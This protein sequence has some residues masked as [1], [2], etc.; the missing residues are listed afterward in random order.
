[1]ATKLTD[2]L[3]EALPAPARGNR[4]TYDTEA[5]GLGVRVT[6]AG[7]RAFV[8]NYRTKGGTERRITLGDP[9]D[10]TIIAARKVAKDLRRRVDGGEDPMGELHAVREAPTVADLAARFEA[11]HLTKR[12]TSTAGDYESMLRRDIL[13]EFGSRKVVEIETGDIEALHAKI[14]KGTPKRKAAPYAANR[15]VAVLSK[16][17]ALSIK[18]KMR[19]DNPVIGI[20]RAPEQKRQ[21]Y[22]SPA[23]IIRLSEALAAHPERASADAVR[24]LLLT[25]ARRGEVLS[26]S[27]NQFD[28]SAGA[29]TKPGA[30]TKQKTDHR[31]P[32]SAPALQLLGE[33]KTA[34]DVETE[35]RRQRGLAPIP[36]LFPGKDGKPL[37]EIKHFWAS[38]CRSAKIEGVRI[39]DLRHTHASILASLGL[40]LP[41]IGA[42]LGHTQAATTHRYAH[43]MDDPLRAATERLGAIV[44]GTGQTEGDVVPMAAGRRL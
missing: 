2:K 26:A 44:T 30:T 39:H 11:E 22:L 13:P 29:W 23:E 28:W 40:S 43:L 36:F 41:I 8:F 21:R 33:M 15:V 16:M 25:G 37:A 4:I 6:A 17:F 42:L 5:R 38:V 1:M 14:A 9:A 27:W 32:L 35:R 24:L 20:E 10:H 19:S 34:A 18:W 31:I 7:A 3:I 12:R